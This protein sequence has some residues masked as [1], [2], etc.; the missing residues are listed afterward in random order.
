M[1]WIE[2]GAG[3]VDV[4]KAVPRGTV[5]GPSF[6]GKI[7]TQFYK[8]GGTEKGVARQWLQQSDE[9]HAHCRV[10]FQIPLRCQRNPARL[11]G[12]VSSHFCFR[13]VPA[14]AIE[15]R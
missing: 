4:H 11:R 1:K 3:G 8:L 14:A 10:A 2:D 9:F 5:V 12:L 13:G 7:T 6:T 15:I